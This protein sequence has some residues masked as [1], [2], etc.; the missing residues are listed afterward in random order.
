MNIWLNITI[1]ALT[2][3]GGISHYSDLYEQIKSRKSEL[4]KSWKSIVRRTI[5][6]NSSDSE[7]FSGKNDIF[8]TVNGIGS[9]VWGL[10]NY[11]PNTHNIDLTEDDISFP[12]GKLIL[13]QHL[14]RERN[15]KVI[16]EAKRQFKNKF[17]KLFCEICDF[18]FEKRYGELG[19][20]FIEGH[21]SKPVSELSENDE[22]KIEDIVMVCSN[23]HKMLHRKR[24]WLDK[25]SLQK[26]IVK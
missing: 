3:L 19:I 12:E 2:D 21:H 11:I 18:D 20:D 16:L 8:Y 25:E 10:R 14:L 7:A 4:P 17:G 1:E 15:P 5:E 22:T 13:R 6:I 23:C 24:P 9:G 26:L